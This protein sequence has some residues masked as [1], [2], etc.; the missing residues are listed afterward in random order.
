MASTAT[1]TRRWTRT[2]RTEK[3]AAVRKYVAVD[4]KYC[5]GP[6]VLCCRLDTGSCQTAYRATVD[7]NLETGSTLQQTGITTLT[8]P[9]S[10]LRRRRGVGGRDD[11]RSRT[12]TR[13]RARR[14]VP[15]GSARVGQF[16]VS[17]PRAGLRRRIARWA[18]GDS[19]TC[20]PREH[21]FT[22]STGHRVT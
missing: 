7:E 21:L 12:E 22:G 18:T 6:E 4:R 13:R 16:P 8:S 9:G 19:R 5:C 17:E 11:S 20:G 1:K 2:C 3:A 14:E 15:A 10:T